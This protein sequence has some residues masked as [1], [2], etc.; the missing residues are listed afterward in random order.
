LTLFITP[1][2]YVYLERM[3]RFFGRAEQAVPQSAPAIASQHAA[4]PGE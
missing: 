3:R 1:V 4:E 2:I